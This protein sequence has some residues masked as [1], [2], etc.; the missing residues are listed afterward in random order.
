MEAKEILEAYLED[1]NKKAI[2]NIPELVCWIESL[3]E[4]K[5]DRPLIV[6]RN[7]GGGQ[8][9]SLLHKAYKVGEPVYFFSEV[10]EASEELIRLGHSTLQSWINNV[11]GGN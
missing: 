7:Q 6:N 11:S 8:Y 2:N 3:F 10:P 1:V 5:L 9:F 4:K